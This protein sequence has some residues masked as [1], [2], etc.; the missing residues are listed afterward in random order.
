MICKPAEEVRRRIGGFMPILSDPGT[1][2]WHVKHI[3]V[4]ARTI[5][6]ILRP[7]HPVSGLQWLPPEVMPDSISHGNYSTY[8]FMAENSWTRVGTESLV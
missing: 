7:G 2:L 6:K 5:K 3:P 4:V 8:N 1:F